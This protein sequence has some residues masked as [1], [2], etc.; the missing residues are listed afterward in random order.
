MLWKMRQGWNKCLK[1]G[2][3]A[4]KMFKSMREFYTAKQYLEDAT[5]SLVRVWINSVKRSSAFC[6]V[7]PFGKNFCSNSQAFLSRESQAYQNRPGKFFW[8]NQSIKFF[9]SLQC[10]WLSHR[11]IQGL[12]G[13][14]P[15]LLEHIVVWCLERRYPKQN[16]AIRQNFGNK[17]NFQHICKQLYLYFCFGSTHVFLL[18]H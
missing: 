10:N 5:V 9:E 11:C 18:C 3:P 15:Q 4:A 14:F 17:D 6:N 16:S 1:W 7:R 12:G 8:P 13:H 2:A